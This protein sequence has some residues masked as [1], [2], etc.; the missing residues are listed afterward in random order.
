MNYILFYVILIF[1]FFFF[2][3]KTAYEMLRSLVGSEMCIRDS[4]DVNSG[5]L[6]DDTLHWGGHSDYVRGLYL[7]NSNSNADQSGWQLLSVADDSTAAMQPLMGS[8]QGG[9]D[10]SVIQRFKIHNEMVM[11]LCATPEGM[12]ATGSEDG[13]VRLW[14]LPFPAALNVLNNPTAT[15][16]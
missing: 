3:Q 12:V 4:F 1:M 2:K 7:L 13:S 11:A 10:E 9:G 8:P 6:S 15:T 16:E 14:K 5:S